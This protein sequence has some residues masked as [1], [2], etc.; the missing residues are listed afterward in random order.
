MRCFIITAVV[1]AF[2]CAAQISAPRI[3]MVLD[4]QGR[5]RPVTGV[6]GNLVPGSP[7]AGNVV[8]GASAGVASLIKTKSD[9]QI[10]TTAGTVHVKAPEGPALFAFSATGAPAFVWLISSQTLLRWNGGDLTQVTPETAAIAGEVIAIGCTD[11]QHVNVAVPRNGQV[12]VLRVELS[13][14]AIAGTTV[15]PNAIGAPLLRGDGSILYAT[16][17]ALVLRDALGRERS[18]AF[19]HTVLNIV[20]MSANWA[21]VTSTEGRRHFAVRI[22][23]GANFQIPEVQ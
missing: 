13:N 23:D 14:G 4:G 6:A 17:S 10:V 12:E 5:F 20:P 19:P 2:S 3:G 9:L 18:T 11:S 8:S 16:K 1:C 7:L 15:L 21:L 22:A